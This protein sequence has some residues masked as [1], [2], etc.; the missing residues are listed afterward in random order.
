MNGSVRTAVF[1]T[2]AL[3]MLFGAVADAFVIVPDLAGDLTE[4]GVR[5]TVLGGT[6]LRL[7]FGAMAMFGFALMVAAAAVQSM[8]GIAPART[9]LAI[10]ATI[11][12]VFGVMAFSRSHNPHHLGPL[13]MGVLLAGAL[14]LPGG[15]R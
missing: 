5:A 6:I 3:L 2:A 15:A 12:I 1:G 13:V 11:E 14:A 9:P 7:R 8:R 10:V 4:L